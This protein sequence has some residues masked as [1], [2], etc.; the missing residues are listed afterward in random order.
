MDNTRQQRLAEF[1][2]WAARH[3]RGDEKGE[4]HIFLDHLFRACGQPGS[5]DVGG[6][7][8]Y[9]IRKAKEDGGGVAFADYVW[10]PVVLIEMK[11][12]GQNLGRHFRQAFDDWI[13]LAPNRPNGTPDLPP[14]YPHPETLIT[15]DCISP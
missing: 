15:S 8:E 5:L 12:R 14:S 9:R 11:K 3:I 10:R 6:Q 4:A 13:R 7:P 2:A 1:T